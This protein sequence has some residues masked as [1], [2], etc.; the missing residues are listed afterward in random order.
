GNDVR[1][2]AGHLAGLVS[3]AFSNDG[4]L[5]LAGDRE[6]K[7]K[8]WEVETGKELQSLKIPGTLVMVSFIGNDHGI[9]ASQGNGEIVFWAFSDKAPRL[10]IPDAIRKFMGTDQ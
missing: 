3:L 6:Q 8:L 10:L 2:L 9:A 4:K 7:I 5:L 1:T